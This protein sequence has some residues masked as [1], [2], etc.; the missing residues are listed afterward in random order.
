M[1]LSEWQSLLGG[2]VDGRTVQHY[3]DAAAEL[4]ATQTSNIICDLSHLGLLSVSGEDAVTFLQGQLTNDVNALDGSTTHL[5]GYC[6]PKGRLLA[7]FL[8]FKHQDQIHLQLPHALLAPISKR[9]Q[10]FIM[11]SKVTLADA[12]E[13]L[14]QFGVNGPDAENLLA[15]HVTHLPTADFGQTNQDNLTVIKLPSVYGARYQIITHF[16]Q[17]KTL[18]QALKTDCTSVGQACWDSLDIQAGLPTVT[19]ET[20]QQFVPQM[21]NLDLL[22]G[23]NFKK[24]CYTGQEIVAR[25]HYLGSVKRRTYLARLTSDSAPNAGIPCLDADGNDAGQ[26]VRVAPKDNESYW[27]LAELRHAA[28]NTGEITCQGQ[29]LDFSDL[30]YSLEAAEA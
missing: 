24:G 16:E 9:L 12:S 18:W 30:P 25:T 5:S 21:L 8:A 10:M 27:V 4:K 3:G 14:I 15:A 23:I 28:K 20:Q 17:A 6:N 19:T 11:R 2:T 29:V 7:L 13:T 26:I 22:N 1:S